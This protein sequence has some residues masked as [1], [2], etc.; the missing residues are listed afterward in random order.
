MEPYKIEFQTLFDEIVASMPTQPLKNEVLLAL[1][2]ALRRMNTIMTPE[3][4][5]LKNYRKHS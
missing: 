5:I 2:K 4:K 3:K 1:N